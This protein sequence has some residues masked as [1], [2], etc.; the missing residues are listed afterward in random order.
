MHE[1]T[2][3][4]IVAPTV[5]DNLCTAVL[6]YIPIPRCSLKIFLTLQ[7]YTLHPLSLLTSQNTS[8]DP[9]RP[10]STATYSAHILNSA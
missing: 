7:F 10:V 9:T 4:K 3:L 2:T 1:K 6:T 5:L 8:E